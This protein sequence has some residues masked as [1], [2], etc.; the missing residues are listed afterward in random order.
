MS[1]LCVKCKRVEPSIDIKFALYCSPCFQEATYHKYRTMLARSR[2]QIKNETPS[3]ATLILFPKNFLTDNR[4]YRASRALLHFTQLPGIQE[5]ARKNLVHY[6]LALPVL[7][8]MERE[9]DEFVQEVRQEYPLLGQIYIILISEGI[10]VTFEEFQK[11][12]KCT[13]TTV[14]AKDDVS[15]DVESLPISNT[16]KE[17]ILNY[18][19][20]HSQLKLMSS[21]KIEKALTPE[22]STALASYILTCT[23]KGRGKFIPFD[24]GL[25]RSFP[26]E[27]C[28]FQF[29]FLVRPLKDI[30][31]KEIELYFKEV[32][33]NNS[34]ILSLISS[35]N[36]NGNVNNNI[37]HLTENFLSN[38]ESEN[39]GT[40]NVVI[41]TSSKV[42]T[43][44]TESLKR[45]RICL[46]PNDEV[47]EVCY[48]CYPIKEY[49]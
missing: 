14:E 9:L 35:E 27:N 20:L 13:A 37:D 34:L 10:S 32:N 44:I 15:H 46:A 38:L 11:R 12:F 41:R 23:C 40:A 48:S 6:N 31:D 1:S 17:D 21:L 42:T 4:V 30:S 36:G 26:S 29:Q 3:P 25:V 5:P 28:Q 47:E 49:F 39:P 22:T 2:E 7:T 16:H 33:F 24:S 8:K 18:K 45:C 19:L 43:G